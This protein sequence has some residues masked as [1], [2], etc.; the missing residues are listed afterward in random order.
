MSLGLPI[1]FAGVGYFLPGLALATVARERRRKILRALPSALEWENVVGD[2]FRRIYL[3]TQMRR[4][5]LQVMQ[6]FQRRTGLPEVERFVG[7]VVQS[8]A[9]GVP[10]SKLLQEQAHD[11]RQASRQRAETQARIAP[12][13]MLFPMVLLILPALFIVII[14]PA[15]PRVLSVFGTTLR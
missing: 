6:E 5:R 1:A 3:E 10:I 2:E 14:A 8:E 12:I 4:P 9:M 7:A 15:V 13:K 11:L